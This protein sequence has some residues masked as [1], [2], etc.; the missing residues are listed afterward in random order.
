[1]PLDIDLPPTTGPAAAN[2]S[3][4]HA[5]RQ[6]RRRSAHQ[7]RTH[8]HLGNDLRRA[9]KDLGLTQA[10]LAATAGCSILALRQAEA[11]LGALT[12]FQALA[13]ACAMQIDA[14]S[15]PPGDTIGVRLLALRS[16]LKLG[17]RAAAA[18]A[19]TSATTVAAIECGRACHTSAAVRLAAALGAPL[20][21]VPVGAQAS[22]WNAAGT[23]SA[24]HGWTTPPAIMEALY[25]VVGGAFGL[26]P[27]SPIKRGADAPV[28]AR[29][30][31]TAEDDALALS[32][33]A[34]SVFVNPPYGRDLPKWVAKARHE[35]ASGRATLVVALIPARTDTRWWHAEVAGLADVWLLKGRLSFGDGT[36]AAP[37]PS[38]LVVWGASPTQ[39][40]LLRDAFPNAWFVGMRG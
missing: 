12:V 29:I 11:T 34:E 13:A 3:E 30:R 27:C 32:W 6:P 37:F 8:S 28:R 2:A 14:K 9:R 22:F 4:S 26:D 21:L 40:G 5:F 1:M 39:R 31:F 17:R 38:A 10:E 33:R 18:L 35:Q 20:R 24:Y 7:N 16:R 25:P 19:G 23:S 15:L 36:Q